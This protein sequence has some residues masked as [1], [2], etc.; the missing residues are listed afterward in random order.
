MFGTVAARREQMPRWSPTAGRLTPSLSASPPPAAE[1]EPNRHHLPCSGWYCEGYCEG[2]WRL[3]GQGL[4]DLLKLSDLQLAQA[5]DY[6]EKSDSEVDVAMKNFQS[7]RRL[8]SLVTWNSFAA[9]IQCDVGPISET[10]VLWRPMDESIAASFLDNLEESPVAP[11]RRDDFAFGYMA[12]LSNSILSYLNESNEYR[13]ATGPKFVATL[14]GFL[15]SVRTEIESELGHSWRVGSYRQFFLQSG[16]TGSRHLDGWPASMRKLFILPRGAT[17]Q[18]GTTWFRLRNGQELILD[19]E[20]PIWV[21]FENSTI[22]HALMSS[23]IARP[24]IEVDLLPASST[25][26]E[27]FYAGNNGWYP[28]FPTDAGLLEGTRLALSLAENGGS[29]LQLLPN[30]MSPIRRFFSSRK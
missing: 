5:V 4:H 30:L 16:T 12:T 15:A 20:R 7:A 23:D 6:R 2:Y 25:S 28:W 21:I 29:R 9:A 13:D 10:G 19:S 26:A 18:S 11:L 17:R 8:I 22:M 24:T 1:I 27:P 14:R 3:R